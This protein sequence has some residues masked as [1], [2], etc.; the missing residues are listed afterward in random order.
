[1]AEVARASGS[2]ITDCLSIGGAPVLLNFANFFGRHEIDEWRDDASLAAAA[3]LNQ[4]ASD[5]LVALEPEIMKSS[6]V[7]SLIG[8][9]AFIASRVSPLVR[10]VIEPI[11]TRLMEEANLRLGEIVEHQAVWYD[12]PDAPGPRPQALDGWQDMALAAGPLAGGAAIAVALPAMAISTTTTWLGLVTLT[13]ISWPVVA[14]GGTIAGVAV[15]TGAMNFAKIPDKAR[16]RLRIKVRDYVSGLIIDGS[17][18]HPSIISR[19]IE[20]IDRAAEQAKRIR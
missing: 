1:M 13:T 14:I 17:S 10:A 15:A 3:V 16:A 5:L 19:V 6:L 9:D 4:A 11:V 20:S 18:E 2:D 8:V 7:D 12:R